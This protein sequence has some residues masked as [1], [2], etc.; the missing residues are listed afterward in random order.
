MSLTICILSFLNKMLHGASGIKRK[1]ERFMNENSIQAKA[2][3]AN[4]N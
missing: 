3:V 1:K 2:F 4:E